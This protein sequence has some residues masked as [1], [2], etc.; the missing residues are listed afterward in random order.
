VTDLSA[1]LRLLP[2][3]CYNH[4][5]LRPCFLV[6]DRE[7]STGIS[8]RKL[9]IETAKFNVITA[10][11]SQ[12]A[13]DTVRKFP[14][15]DGVVTDSGMVDMPCDTLLAQIREISPDIPLVVVDTPS[16]TSCKLATHLLDTF[17]P[18]RLLRLLESI[19]PEAATVIEKRNEELERLHFDRFKES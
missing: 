1:A 3:R 6:V 2:S 13:I 19:F 5:M 16:G 4:P 14:A 15:I 11:S 8:T 12:E 7:T 17:D 18:A 9:I 10:Y